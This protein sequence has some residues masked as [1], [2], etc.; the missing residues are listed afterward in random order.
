[1]MM[2]PVDDKG[3]QPERYSN[4]F[5]ELPPDPTSRLVVK[6]TLRMEDLLSFQDY[7]LSKGDRAG[8]AG[9]RQVKFVLFMLAL[10]GLIL[11]LWEPEGLGTIPL[12]FA[13]AF[14]L[15]LGL[16]SCRR[17][18]L[19][20]A[21]KQNMKTD[22]SLFRTT[23]V[24][25]MPEA[26]QNERGP[27]TLRVLWEGVERIATTETHLFLYTS[28]FQAI[29][30]PGWAFASEEEFDEFIDSARHYRREALRNLD[31][32]FYSV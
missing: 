4:R 14:V 5:R 31:E 23:H 22:R 27:S 20:A 11:F 8:R 30:V 21:A 13:V 16:L 9:A 7:H 15:L 24:L 28:S 6:F 19:R 2:E 29:I 32:E 3:I 10:A 26:V 25:L 17:P 12:A 18:L 1:M